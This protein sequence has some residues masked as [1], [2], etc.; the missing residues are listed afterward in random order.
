MRIQPGEMIAGQAALAVRKLMKYGRAFGP[1]TSGNSISTIAE[2]LGT[3]LS[4]AR[5]IFQELCREGYIEPVPEHHRFDK[6]D[7]WFT[8]IKGNV[9]AHASTRKPITR[10]T[11][12]RLV[13]EFLARVREINAGDYAYRVRRVIV[14]GSF[15]S[16]SPDLGD[17][18]LSIELVDPYRGSDERKA[19]HEARIEAALQAGRRFGDYYQRLFWPKQEGWLKLK[20][21]SPSLSLHNEEQ[22]QVRSRAIPSR[23]IFD[24]STRPDPPQAKVTGDQR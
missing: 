13:E 5:Q 20:H 9:L 19:A 2:V 16:D 17:V 21:R 1:T 4:Q 23:I 22:E 12:E 10:K 8:T 6:P 15:L 24:S 14:F 18:D 11:A 3:D 7:R